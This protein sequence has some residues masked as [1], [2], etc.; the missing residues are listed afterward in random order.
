MDHVLQQAPMQIIDKT[1]CHAKNY[2]AIRIAIKDSMICGGGA[3]RVPGCQGDSDGPLSCFLNCRW[4]L[5]G[6]VSHGS[7]YCQSSKTYTIFARVAKFQSWI[8]QK[9][10]E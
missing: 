8:K 3:P 7:R 6:A 1:T 9:T 2:R 5:H 4:E 10:S